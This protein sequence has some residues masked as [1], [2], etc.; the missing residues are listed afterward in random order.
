[1][2]R[3]LTG[4]R[5]TG[6][7]HLGHYLG[8]LK[9]RVRLQDEYECFFIIADLQVFTDHLH[10]FKNINSNVFEVACDYLGVGLKEDNCFF[11]QSQVPELAELS[12]YFSFLVNI[13]EL[14][15]NPTVRSEAELYGDSNMNLGFFSYPVSQA[16]DILAFKADVVP[17]GQDQLPHIFQAREIV[18]IFNNN[19]GLT[20]KDPQELIG[21][22]PVLK[23]VDGRKM[24]KSLGNTI[25]FAQTKEET[26]K[27]VL[28]MLTDEG[29]V[30][31]RDPGN[32]QKCLAFT[33]LCFFENNLD[34]IHATENLCTSAGI[35]CRD[36]KKRISNLINDELAE[37]REKRDFYH[38]TPETVWSILKKG[39]EKARK[40]ASKTLKEV[41]KAMGIS[42]L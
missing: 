18:R 16:A 4:D 1:M 31:L 6:N 21:E 23:G 24:S 10:D 25:S 42:Y 19:F 8:T 39:N 9:N 26:E 36:C 20:F 41:R 27:K 38:S 13:S 37:I 22:C 7:L 11:I 5:P 30:R 28:N 2:K 12:M 14:K 35:S 29:R 32:P 34:E 33:Y 3:I 15:R 17:C 40:E